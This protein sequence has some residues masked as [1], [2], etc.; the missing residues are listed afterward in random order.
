MDLPPLSLPAP[1]LKIFTSVEAYQV[2]MEL[3]LRGLVGYGTTDLFLSV[4][5]LLGYSESCGCLFA[6]VHNKLQMQAPCVQKWNQ[7]LC[8]F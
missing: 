5:F 7:G 6:H 4:H 3:S 1:C 2:H 8:D